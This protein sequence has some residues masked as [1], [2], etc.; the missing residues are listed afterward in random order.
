M[1]KPGHP[2]AC[3]LAVG[4]LLAAD[5]GL[6]AAID[7]VEHAFAAATAV[8][9]QLPF[10]H[11][12]YYEKEMG[13]GIRRVYAGIEGWWDPGELASLKLRANGI[14]QQ[15]T[16]QGRRRLNVDPGLLNLSQLVLAS[17]KFS[18]HR[19]YVG[20]GIYAE[21]EY[22]YERGTFRPL[23]WTYPDYR[24]PVA[25]RFFNARREAHKRARK[26]VSCS[27]A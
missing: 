25:I 4:L 26:D 11:V 7:E 6:D 20:Q 14:E 12:A 3:S 16:H 27:R 1:S 21:V 9:P 13:C 2:E 10:P 17:G 8:S 19:V 5:M 24:E 15:W 18:A 23:P 22:V